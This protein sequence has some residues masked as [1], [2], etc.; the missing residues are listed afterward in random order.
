[1][2]KLLIAL[3][4]GSTLLAGCATTQTTQSGTVGVQRKQFMMLSS[5]QVDGMAAQSY[6][7]TLKEADTKKTLNTN[8]QETERVRTIAK[9][10]IAQTTVFRPDA[11]NWKWEVNVQE[12]KELNAY[13]MPGGKI[14]VYSGLIE[15]LNTTDDELASVM[16]HE[17]SHALREHGRERMSEAYAQQIGLLGLAAIVGATTNNKNNAAATAQV[18]AAVAAVALTLPHS[19]EQEREADRMGLELSAR[20]GYDPNAAVSL[21]RKMGANG[22]GKPPEWLSTHPSDESRIN[23]L[24]KLIPTVMPLYQEAKA[25]H[26]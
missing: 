18:G 8:V 24:Q 26:S 16:G 19:R 23:D 5:K 11:A 20:A 12:S 25:K 17:I 9:R 3:L 21:W 7:Q 22:G 14:M 13:C 4:A 1:M 15:K 10:L 6:V 2:K